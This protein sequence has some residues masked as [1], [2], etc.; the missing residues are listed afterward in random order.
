MFFW[1]AASTIPSPGIWTRIFRK[2]TLLWN[3]SRREVSERTGYERK[4]RAPLSQTARKIFRG[5]YAILEPATREPGPSSIFLSFSRSRTE[6]H[7]FLGRPCRTP[8]E[9]PRRTKHFASR[10]LHTRRHRKIFSGVPRNSTLPPSAL[11]RFNS[12]KKSRGSV[13]NSGTPC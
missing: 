11:A 10:Q 1:R 7:R 12:I 3:R 8:F 6:R 2:P 4:L 13:E 9:T 5:D